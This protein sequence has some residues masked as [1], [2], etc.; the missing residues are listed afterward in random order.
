MQKQSIV[1]TTLKNPIS[2]P[3]KMQDYINYYNKLQTKL[4]TP[5]STT[6]KSVMQ[7]NPKKDD[8]IAEDVLNEDFNEKKKD[9]K[10]TLRSLS[11][12]FVNDTRT[13]TDDFYVVDI[14]ASH[15]NPL[16]GKLADENSKDSDSIEKLAQAIISPNLEIGSNLKEALRQDIDPNNKKWAR[17]G[18]E[19]RDS[20]LYARV[21]LHLIEHITRS[22][23]EGPFFKVL[24]E[25]G[26]YK[27]VKAEQVHLNINKGEDSY[28]DYVF[29]VPRENFSA[30]IQV[31]V[32][33]L[34]KT[35]HFFIESNPRTIKKGNLAGSET[36]IKPAS[37]L[38]K[39][40]L[41]AIVLLLVIALPLLIIK[42]KRQL[43]E[44]EYED[45]DEEDEE[46]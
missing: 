8:E 44:Y 46:Y 26:D 43:E 13:K 45:Y 35:I 40:I 27:L 19:R 37:P 5:A 4:D 30:M 24:Q 42:R 31:N 25:N 12:F 32:E 29:E 20:K 14:S 21:R 41:L 3:S 2:N 39:T 17:A 18:L 7:K 22:V 1:D 33:S 23:D 10:P 36:E 11:D 28:A 15:L 38:V 34:N 6:V 16:T 9:E